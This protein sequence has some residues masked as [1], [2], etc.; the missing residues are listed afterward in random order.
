MFTPLFNPNAFLY[1]CVG[2]GV[3][4]GAC[5]CACVCV[6]VWHMNNITKILFTFPWQNQLTFIYYNSKLHVH[7]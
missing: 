3:G 4:V 2:M 1:V 5:A 7:E 6:Y